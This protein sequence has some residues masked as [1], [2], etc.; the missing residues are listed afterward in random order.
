MLILAMMSIVIVKEY[1]PSKKRRNPKHK[2]KSHKKKEKIA[3]KILPDLNQETETNV[4]DSHRIDV[5]ALQVPNK[6]QVPGSAKKILLQSQPQ[7][8]LR[9]DFEKI[10][11]FEFSQIKS[12]EKEERDKE[13]E[14]E[15][16]DS[17]K[18]NVLA[19]GAAGSAKEKDAVAK[20]PET[21]KYAVAAVEKC[22]K[23][24]P[25]RKEK[26]T[27]AG[28]S[29]LPHDHP[30]SRSRSSSFTSVTDDSE[31][32]AI[33]ATP[34][35]RSPSSSL[36][37]SASKVPTRKGLV[38]PRGSV[39]AEISQKQ[40]LEKRPSKE[41]ISQN[42]VPDEEKE[43]EKE[44]HLLRKSLSR[45]RLKEK[46]ERERK[47]REERERREEKE[48]REEREKKERE[49]KERREE[50]EKKE[51]EEKERREREEKEKKERE[52]REK[53]E[54]ERREREEKERERRR[55]EKEE[56]ER[57]ERE[58][59]ERKE[60][61]E[62]EERERREREERDRKKKEMEQQKRQEREQREKREKEE[63]EKERGKREKEQL[64][65]LKREKEKLDKRK[66]KGS[67]RDEREDEDW[68]FV[69]RER[70]RGE[71]F[72]H[73][74][75]KERKRHPFDI[76]ERPDSKASKKVP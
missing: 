45:E 29:D 76:D 69:D 57:R 27:V 15:R 34:S 72:V 8:Q 44:R 17:I 30:P 58:E 66:I 60:R 61:K 42:K 12:R 59:K 2:F 51:R 53:R 49:E 37:N 32:E 5:H 19:A 11:E 4:D 64:Q 43:K 46:T 16:R 25:S 1:F 20:Y 62:K 22:G 75:E 28:H 54:R 71:R 63:R 9:V 74:G 39:V 23:E 33:S 7:K 10:L 3:P 65:R 36:P 26:S 31:K 14:A 48:R 68:V 18:S 35:P 70:K 6:N 41:K 40:D 21:P 56:R 52:E 38:S 24:F 73:V 50:R 13:V 55:K 67:A 47:E